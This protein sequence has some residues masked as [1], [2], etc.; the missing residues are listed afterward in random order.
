M[1]VYLLPGN[2]AICLDRDSFEHPR[3]I[4]DMRNIKRA[5]AYASD[6]EWVASL[7]EWGQ[8]KTKPIVVTDHA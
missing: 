6:S 5:D 7:P 4:Y 3:L 8:C 1:V 2:L